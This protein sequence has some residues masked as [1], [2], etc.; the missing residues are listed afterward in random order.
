MLAHHPLGGLGDVALLEEVGR[1][2]ALCHPQCGPLLPRH[3]EMCAL[4]FYLQLLHQPARDATHTKPSLSNSDGLLSP[5]TQARIIL[6]EVTLVM[7]SYRS[8][9]RVTQT[10]ATSRALLHPK[11][12]SGQ[13]KPDDISVRLGPPTGQE[14]L[15]KK[16]KVV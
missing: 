9:R 13:F 11:L 12:Y 5:G 1:L 10:A 2:G 16:A 3:S 15:P 14:R 8:N 4:S 7:V 6:L